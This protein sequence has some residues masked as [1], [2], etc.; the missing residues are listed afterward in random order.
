MTTGTKPNGLFRKTRLGA[1]STPVGKTWTVGNR[2][3]QDRGGDPKDDGRAGRVAGPAVVFGHAV[4]TAPTRSVRP[5]GQT[6]NL[7]DG[8]SVLVYFSRACA[9]GA[10]VPQGDRLDSRPNQAGVAQS[11]ERLTRN[12]QVRGSIPLPGS[13]FPWILEGEQT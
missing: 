6:K 1:M 3:H 8:R 2:R 4:P 12:E 7:V 11:A 10:P 5:T 9:V 13:M